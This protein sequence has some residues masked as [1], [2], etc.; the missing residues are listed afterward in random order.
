MLA[1]GG[2]LR[3]V[4]GVVGGAWDSV[5]GR[6]GGWHSD[7]HPLSAASHHEG[8]TLLL[9]EYT[10]VIYKL[11]E[12][13]ARSNELLRLLLPTVLPTLVLSQT[14]IL[15]SGPRLEQSLSRQ[16]RRET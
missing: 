6:A 10:Y 5:L 8:K 7:R 2:A 3:R 9:K 12:N 4:R 11:L 14:N 13:S 1:Q 15:R 16:R